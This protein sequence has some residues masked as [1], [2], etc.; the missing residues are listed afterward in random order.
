[1][2]EK[3]IPRVVGNLVADV[4]AA[5]GHLTTGNPCTK[6]LLEELVNYGHGDIAYQ[7][8][9]QKTY[10]GWGYMLERGGTTVWER[11]EELT[12]AGMNSLNHPMLA[13][14]GSWFYKYLGGIRTDPQGPGF[15]RI[16]IHPCPMGDLT[17]VRSEYTSMY[18]V[19]RSAWRR[20]GKSFRLKVT[21]PVN[22]TAR[23]YV[24]ASD[25]SDVGEGGKP[26]ASAEGVKWVRNE[27]GA[28]VFE[29]G[30]GD[31]EFVAK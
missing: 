20:E 11:W 19:I 16:I 3:Q 28:V 21:V 2:P 17:W 1:V 27:N 8:L 30:S 18:G 31:Y 9:T 13:P 5:N 15:K 10:P 12:G 24:P 23:V 29:V 14:V 7:I 6:F 26:A 22:T 4:K 25:V